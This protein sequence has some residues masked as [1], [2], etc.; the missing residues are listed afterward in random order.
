M[1]MIRHLA[2]VLA[3]VA[4]AVV[5]PIA[6]AETNDLNYTYRFSLAVESAQTE[7]ELADGVAARL[8]ELFPFDSTCTTLPPT[9]QRC[10]FTAQAEFAELGAA[11]PVLVVDRVEN[12]WTFRTL[13][14]H[15]EGPD[16]YIAFRF[17][18]NEDSLALSVRST[19]PSLT[20]GTTILNGTAQ[21]VWQRF[22]TNI[23]A[24]F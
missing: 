12:G 6:Q 10:D 15:S 22:A 1:R 5:A 21:K 3:I 8:G 23:S 4:A 17:E 19:G 2:G 9:G 11:N 7:T 14:E 18:N 24:G 20:T 16:R 13:K